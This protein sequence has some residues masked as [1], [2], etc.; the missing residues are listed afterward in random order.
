MKRFP[1][2]PVRVNNPDRLS[3]VHSGSRNA[4]SLSSAYTTTCRP[5]GKSESSV[6]FRGLRT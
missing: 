2:P 4:V 1:L 5:D 3:V 6:T